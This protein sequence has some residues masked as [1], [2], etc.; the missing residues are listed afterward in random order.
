VITYGEF[1]DM[2]A[3]AAATL[4]WFTSQFG[5]TP[6]SVTDGGRFAVAPTTSG[7][8]CFDARILT[9]PRRGC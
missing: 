6:V 3:S 9:K 8:W 5:S 7:G 1:Q 4:R 2:G